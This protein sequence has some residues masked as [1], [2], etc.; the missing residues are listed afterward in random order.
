MYL[1]ADQTLSAMFLP[2]K[3]VLKLFNRYLIRLL[4]DDPFQSPLIL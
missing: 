4:I 3:Y 2:G 1:D